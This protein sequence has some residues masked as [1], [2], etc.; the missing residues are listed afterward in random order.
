MIDPKDASYIADLEAEI[1]KLRAQVQ[2]RDVE[3]KRLRKEKGLS[4][5]G[6][7]LTFNEKTGTHFDASGKHFCTKCLLQN[8]RRTP[9][10]VEPHGWR[11]LLCPKYYSDPDRPE[12]IDHG[13]GSWMT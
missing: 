6:E 8:D 3:I 5:A 1:E 13:G 10:K 2:E 9:L 11:C 12:Q 7:G 4:S